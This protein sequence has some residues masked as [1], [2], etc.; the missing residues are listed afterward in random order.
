MAAVILEPKKIKP[1]TVCPSISHEVMGPEPMP[2]Q[3]R[4][5]VLTTGAPEQSPILSFLKRIAVQRNGS[6]STL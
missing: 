5:E 1:A 6:V 4:H 2:L 3:W